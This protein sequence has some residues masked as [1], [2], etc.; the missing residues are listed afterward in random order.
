MSRFAS[1]LSAVVLAIAGATLIPSP[2]HAATAMFVQESTWSSGYVGRFTVTNDGASAMPNWRVEFDLPAGTSIGHSWDST[3]T[4]TGSHYVVTGARWNASLAPGASTTFGWV[5]AGRGTPQACLLNG[6]SCDG[7]PPVRDVQPP[8]TPGNFRGGG[9]GSTFTLQW[10]PSTDDTGVTAYEIYT[11]TGSAPFATVTGTKHTMPPP[12]PMVFTFGVRAI[13]AAGNRSPFATLGLGT[14]PDVTP[15]GPPANL[16]LS[17]PSGGYFPVRWDA[18]R[19]D[20]FV[21]GYEVSLNGR[22]VTRVGNTSAFVPYNGFGTY[23][24][25]V[26]AFDGAGNFSS[27]VQIGIAIDPPPP[28]PPSSPAVRHG[29]S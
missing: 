25:G 17:G 3:L 11:N 5:A 23:M 20:Q 16:M 27:Q 21:A 6:A 29:E 22:V 15:P 19:D 28:P 18:A 26:R 12:P 9:Q 13:D 4:R 7:R 24:V 2:A 10:D 1:R 14:P 8:S